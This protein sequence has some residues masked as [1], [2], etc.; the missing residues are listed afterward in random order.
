MLLPNYSRLY[1]VT[2]LLRGSSK[3]VPP[4]QVTTGEKKPVSDGTLLSS[5]VVVAVF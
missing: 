2:G 1:I 3:T 5:T 4:P